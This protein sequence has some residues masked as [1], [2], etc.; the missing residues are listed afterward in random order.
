MNKESFSRRH[1]GTR[2]SDIKEMLNA[3]DRLMNEINI[4]NKMKENSWKFLNRDFHVD[5]SKKLI[6][7]SLDEK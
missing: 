7:K 1:I 2:E 3:I 4:F 6:I 5:R